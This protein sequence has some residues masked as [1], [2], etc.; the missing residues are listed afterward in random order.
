MPSPN[1]PTPPV[2]L[3]TAAEAGN[4]DAQ[5]DLGR[6]YAE[7]SPE[8]P[9]AQWWLRR[10]ANQG[11]PRAFHNMGVLAAQAEDNPAAIAWFRKAVAADWRNSIFP[12][13]KLLQ[14]SGDMPGAL[15]IY[16]RGIV[17]GCADSMHAMSEL[18]LEREISELYE[19]A[20]IWCEKAVAKGHVGAHMQL[21]RI[22]H[23]GLGVQPDPRQAVSL[24]LRAAWRGHPGAQLM[25]G[26][27]C[28]VGGVLKEDRV[29][30][31][32]FLSASAAQGNEGGKA[33]LGS[34]E[35]KLTRSERARFETEPALY[36][37]S[38]HRHS[39]QAP[40]PH[41]LWAAE[42][43]DVESQNELGVWYAKNLPGT[44]H[45]HRW[46]MRAADQGDGDACHNLGAEARNAG[47]LPLAAEWFKK[48]IAAGIKESFTCLGSILERSGDIA[49]ATEIFQRGAERNCPQCQ[50]GLARLAFCER[51]E[52]SYVRARYWDEKAAAQGNEA[53]QA[54]LGT[55][56]YEGLGVEADA[57]QAVHWWRQ[58]A[59]RGH[60]VAQYRMG[61]AHHKG[62]GTSEDLLAAIRFL[63]ASAALGNEDAKAYL[64]Q[65]EAAL[66]PEE[67]FQFEGGS[68]RAAKL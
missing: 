52:E 42:A 21:A 55:M 16:N 23:E 1:V 10:A 19:N 24:W 59:Q 46:F 3:V 12:L 54:R 64:P 37:H 30:A 35:R 63:S 29:A 34:L 6:W 22:Y 56:Y 48:A 50:C 27:A 17:T 20:H 4:A 18:I 11:L 44:P 43:G 33:C 31:M 60:H 40:P 39:T 25:I 7:K 53:S 68:A 32:H 49:G 28:D 26:V 47:D 14:A 45:A 67:K 62:I 13:G 38:D 66:K 15:D 8:T 51:T 36:I 61:V 58:A 5:C 57:E 2:D 65:V 9:Y 41:L